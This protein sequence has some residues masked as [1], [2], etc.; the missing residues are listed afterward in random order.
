MRCSYQ[1]TTL[2][3]LFGGFGALNRPVAFFG[4][5]STSNPDLEVSLEVPHTIP[6]ELYP[7]QTLRGITEGKSDIAT[8]RR[9]LDATVLFCRRFAL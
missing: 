1:C 4:A 2:E 8:T 3:K 5:V 6:G 7:P 9:K